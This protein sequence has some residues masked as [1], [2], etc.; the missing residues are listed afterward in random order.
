M[1]TSVVIPAH[2]AEATLAAC[3]EGCLCQSES[4]C[5]V[6][7]VDD[8]ST[9]ETGR[10]AQAFPVHYVRQDNR[11]PAAARNR[12]AQE[13]RGDVIAFTDADCVPDARWLA[14]LAAGFDEGVVAVG[15]A[16]GIVNP[17]HWLARM[18]HE[19]IAA[20]HAHLEGDVDFLGS[21]NVAY[22]KA[23][24]DAV[25]GF[26]ASFPCASGEDNDLAYRLQDV[27][28]RL[29]FTREAVVAHHHATRLLPYLRT[30]AR[31]GYW[32]M[33]LYAKHIGRAR[34]GDQYAGMA[35]LAGPPLALLVVLLLAGVAAS[36]F[37]Q[38]GLPLTGPALA[39]VVVVY[40]GLRIRMPLDMVRRSGEAG[41]ALFL[42]VA[43][44]RDVA[45]GLGMVAGMVRFFL[46]DRTLAQ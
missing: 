17:G 12:G 43:A 23:A 7:V 20:R 27:G 37:F 32:R 41:M 10:V 15:G 31:H 14:G 34:R 18:V 42:G 46:I 1:R 29:R 40:V 44:L 3:I 6:I 11:G 9:D 26:D 38:V 30:Q 4:A 24:F 33:K 35:D 21:F 45:R 5:E 39:L 36:S 13:A 16:Y 28:G 22:R 25:G 8:G 19:E 2:N